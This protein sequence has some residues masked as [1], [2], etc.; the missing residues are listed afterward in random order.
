MYFLNEESIDI[1][2]CD[3]PYNIGKDFGNNIDKQDMDTYL[4]WYDN[5]IRECIRIL[6]SNGYGIFVGVVDTL[7]RRKTC[8]YNNQYDEYYKNK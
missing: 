2:I 8:Y 3:T 5:W 1:I 4:L 7:F 6:K